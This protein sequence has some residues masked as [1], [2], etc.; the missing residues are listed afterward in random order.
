PSAA[1]FTPSACI[2]QLVK[3]TKTEPRL[4]APGND[5]ETRGTR[6]EQQ[7]ESWSSGLQS[8]V[9]FLGTALRRF[10]G[11]CSLLLAQSDG[12]RRQQTATNNPCGGY[13]GLTQNKS[14]DPICTNKLWF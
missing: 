8:M 5:R 11:I 12:C 6:L 7:W 13:Q 4:T 10:Q 2:G 1:F 9:R 3:H 14:K